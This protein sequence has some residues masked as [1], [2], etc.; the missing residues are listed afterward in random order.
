VFAP[1]TTTESGTPRPSTSS[2]RFVPIF[3]PVCR[4]APDRLSRQ[5]RLIHT[6]INA[7]PQPRHPFHVRILGQAS[8]PDPFEHTGSRPRHEIGVD[9]AASAE[10]RFR[11][12]LPLDARACNIDDRRQHGSG[13]NRLASCSGRAMVLLGRIALG[14]RQQ[15]LNLR[16]KLI[17]YPPT[18]QSIRHTTGILASAASWL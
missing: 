17:R 3:P 13:R 7:L 18:L 1:D 15:R 12:R 10:L 8:S 11:K 2:E 14:P 5:R 6:A 4:V 9:S 16:P